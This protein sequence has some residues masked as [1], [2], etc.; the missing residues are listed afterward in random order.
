MNWSLFILSISSLSTLFPAAQSQTLYTTGFW[1]WKVTISF[2]CVA[3]PLT[4]CTFSHSHLDNTNASY[5]TLY[6]IS[7]NFL[8]PFQYQLA[9]LIPLVASYSSALLL[10][11][12]FRIIYLFMARRFSK[13]LD[14]KCIKGNSLSYSISQQHVNP[15]GVYFSIFERVSS[16]GSQDITLLAQSYMTFFSLSYLSLISHL[17]K[18][19]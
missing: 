12:Q 4:W 14:L 17:Y 6:M 13:D 2:P 10:L 1:F 8:T 7:C 3:I 11:S 5:H 18:W 16:V 9:S 19:L 15:M